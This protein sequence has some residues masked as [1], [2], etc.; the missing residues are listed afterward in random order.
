[1]GAFKVYHSHTWRPWRPGRGTARGARGRWS[2]RR[3]RFDAV[4]ATSHKIFSKFSVCTSKTVDTNVVEEI[5]SYSN[6]K[7]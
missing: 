7:G 4:N 6:C 3:A 5:T 2:V 1:M